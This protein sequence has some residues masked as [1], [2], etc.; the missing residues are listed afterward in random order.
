MLGLK[1]WTLLIKIIHERRK[2]KFYFI[3]LY[4][5]LIFLRY[6]IAFIETLRMVL[7]KTLNTGD[8]K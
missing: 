6:N 7:M 2:A 8:V 5:F 3:T 1:S 4:S